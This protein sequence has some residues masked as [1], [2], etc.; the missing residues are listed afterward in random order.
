MNL[1][2]DPKL[3]VLINVGMVRNWALGIEWFVKV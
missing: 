1:S 3:F 2:F